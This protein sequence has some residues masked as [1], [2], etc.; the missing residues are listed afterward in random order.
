MINEIEKYKINQKLD[1]L[2]NVIFSLQDKVAELNE[3]MQ[4][5]K[6]KQ[7]MLAVKSKASSEDPMGVDE[8]DTV[9]G[10][11]VFEY[12]WVIDYLDYTNGTYEND[13]HLKSPRYYIGPRS[14]R[15]YMLTYP[16]DWVNPD[17]VNIWG[18]I[19]RGAYDDNL[20]WPF[21]LR[22]DLI[23][24]DQ[25]QENPKHVAVTIWPGVTCNPERWEFTVK[26]RYQ[27][28]NGCG[29]PYIIKKEQLKNRNYLKDGKIM[30]KMRVYLN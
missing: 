28:E 10:T 8:F 3:E 7:T 12:V 4:A 27:T 19:A 25:T 24:L 21:S 13:D 23:L 26:D 2:E 5:L 18:G 15:M 22:F 29:N 6:K 11:Y 20:T 17:W 9:T 1:R 30:F 16:G 14:Y